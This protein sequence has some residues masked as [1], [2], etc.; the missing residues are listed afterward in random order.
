MCLDF[1]SFSQDECSVLTRRA[2]LSVGVQTRISVGTL[3]DLVTPRL[4]QLAA[5]LALV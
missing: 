5:K 4:L 3:E 2:R 1:P